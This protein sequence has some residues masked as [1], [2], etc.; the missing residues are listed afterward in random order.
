[1]AQG[2]RAHVSLILIHHLDTGWMPPQRLGPAG[3]IRWARGATGI[4]AHLE[5]GRLPHIDNGEPIQLVRMDLGRWWS[6]KY[7]R[8]P[9]R[10]W[11]LVDA[12]QARPAL[13]AL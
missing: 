10:E 1:M 7:R 3:Q 2:G 9:F 6:E 8:P 12:P 5:Q 13:I 4:F 11:R